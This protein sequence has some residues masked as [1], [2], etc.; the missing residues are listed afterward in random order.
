MADRFELAGQPLSAVRLKS[1]QNI[2]PCFSLGK[3]RA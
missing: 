2:K 1:L 3:N